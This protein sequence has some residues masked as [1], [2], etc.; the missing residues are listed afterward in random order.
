MGYRIVSY[1][2]IRYDISSPSR[3]R[4]TSKRNTAQKRLSGKDKE[5][6]RNNASQ[7][8]E[9]KGE[10]PPFQASTHDAKETSTTPPVHFIAMRYRYAASHHTSWVVT[11]R[12]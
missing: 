1:A 7:P 4:K 2:K 3:P 10:Q 12:C 5:A 9:K 11:L 8:L 6:R